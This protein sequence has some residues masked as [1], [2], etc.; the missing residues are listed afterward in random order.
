MAVW[1]PSPNRSSIGRAVLAGGRQMIANARH[2]STVAVLLA[3]MALSGCASCFDAATLRS[4]GFIEPPVHHRHSVRTAKAADDAPIPA[5]AALQPTELS[6]CNQELYL[7]SA[8]S[9]EEIRAVEDKCRAL[10]LSQPYKAV[11]D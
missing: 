4:A 11:K 1:S 10:I 9:H 3:G 2:L 8:G 6:K 5:A 7:K